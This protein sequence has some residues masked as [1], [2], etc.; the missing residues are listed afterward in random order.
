[1]KKRIRSANDRMI[2]LII[3]IA[4]TVV[5]IGGILGV[6]TM[7]TY[8]IYRDKGGYAWSVARNSIT[9]GIVRDIENEY[10]NYLV[11]SGYN[12]N[13]SLPVLGNKGYENNSSVRISTN[14]I[15]KYSQSNANFAFAVK[16]RSDTV[17][18]YNY[19][20]ADAGIRADK[21]GDVIEGT[22]LYQ[23]TPVYGYTFYIIGNSMENSENGSV[24]FNEGEIQE[25]TIFI[26]IYVLA[27]DADG[28]YPAS[29]N[30]STANW[31]INFAVNC[32]FIIFGVIALAILLIFI[33][34]VMITN[35]AGLTAD[36]NSD[37]IIP[38]FIDRT[39]LD[40]ALI[41]A[42]GIVAAG[43]ACIRLTYVGDAGL[44]AENVVTI[45][46]SCTIMIVIVNVLETISVRI[47]LGNPGR[48]T[49]IYKIIEKISKRLGGEKPKKKRFKV[50][51][52]TRLISIVVSISAA[53][54]LTLVYFAYRYFVL[55]ATH[56]KFEYY[57]AL[58]VVAAIILLPLMI[59]FVINFGYIRDVGE[60]IASG[61]LETD[62]V[63]SR[64]S[65]KTM[66]DH[67]ENL[68]HIRRDMAKAVAQEM[69]EERFRNELI[70][71]ISHDIRTPLTSINNFVELLSDESITEDQRAEYMEILQRQVKN[72]NGLTKNL[73]DISKF[74]TGIVD[75]NLERMDIGVVVEQMVGEYYFTLQQNGIEIEI[76]KEDKEYP[77]MAD[78]DM[79][80]RIVD[81]LMSNINKYAMPSTRA[82]IRVKD[83]DGKIS[84]MFRN[85]SKDIPD[86][87]GDE[88]AERFVREDKSRH[89]EG[90]GLGLSIAKSL[91]E[92]QH[93][94][95]TPE[96]DG[97]LFT[98]TITFDRA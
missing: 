54:L 89:T 26:E 82:Y 14:V 51:Y 31:W 28:R 98:V 46:I 74:S 76:Q 15:E 77:V 2:A 70:S 84:I 85:V 32:R 56:L 57:I 22:S 42:A 33:L 18:W 91:T 35:G 50:S 83:E 4:L 59:M 52:V 75:V 66:R 16:D 86:L 62:D 49:L 63:S 67:G 17:L 90:S 19:N 40:L 34:L 39:P 38:G 92:L 7:A 97:D 6:S 81:N 23:Y 69:K 79:L 1:M 44:V 68:D 88:L 87:S 30:Y 95:F 64:L 94:V 25:V 27:P 96:T 53:L 12:A 21:N 24:I 60:K 71:N 43:F 61:D 48:T 37:E 11:D 8:N 10:Y 47:K 36:P 93:A 78:G 41:V 9:E 73:M 55:G 80:G 58:S 65:I 29:D 13:D 5:A 72:L 3:I 45:S 20:P